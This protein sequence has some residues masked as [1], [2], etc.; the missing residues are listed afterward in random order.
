MLARQ[1]IGHA[2][3]LIADGCQTFHIGMAVLVL[4][5]GDI[6]HFRRDYA[7]PCIMHLADIFVRFGPPGGA[8]QIETQ[9]RQFIVAQPR[10]SEL[11]AGPVKQLRVAALHNPI[12]PQ[13]FKPVA[14]INGLVGVGIGTR[15]VINIDWR[16]FFTG[17]AR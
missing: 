16:I 7:L 1:H 13:G 6:F 3:A 4:P 8:L 11:R 12:L 14:N 9:R 17:L 2:F 15:C 5:N 10:S